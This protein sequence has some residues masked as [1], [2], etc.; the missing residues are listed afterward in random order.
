MHLF[1]P[2]GSISILQKEYVFTSNTTS[3]AIPI[4]VH[5]NN[6][7]NGDRYFYLRFM[8]L[9]YTYR[10]TLL[11]TEVYPNSIYAIIEDDEGMSITIV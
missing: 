11:V 4:D 6:S 3:L 10:N 7:L 2:V 9:W 5:D 1:T 8:A